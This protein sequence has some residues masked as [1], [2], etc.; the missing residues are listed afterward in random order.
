[1]KILNY[2]KSSNLEPSLKASWLI[3]LI[4]SIVSYVFI[5][6]SDG[7]MRTPLL[8]SS[9]LNEFLNLYQ[10]PIKTLTATVVLFGLWL[11]IERMKQTEEQTNAITDNNRFNNFYKHRD[12]FINFYKTSLY[13]R[14]TLLYTKKV[15]IIDESDAY[16]YPIYS[17]YYYSSYHNFQP[18][19]NSNIIKNEI[20]LLDKMKTSLL[21]IL[22]RDLLDNDITDIKE[23]FELSNFILSVVTGDGFMMSE[24]KEY[25]KNYIKDNNT[26]PSGN[27]INKVVLLIPLY[28]RYIFLLELMAFDGTDV[29]RFE[30]QHF[31]SN[32]SR[33]CIE[34]NLINKNGFRTKRINVD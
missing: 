28:W 25:K 8:N 30:C 31:E 2:F 11:T 12:D 32:Y 23:V 7:I 5:L 6:I 13:Y 14:L 29:S 3:G 20:A 21:N 33:F 16:F 22:N 26:K 27:E 1:M 24:F 19:R 34:Y 9:G 15:T 4:I 18:T 10:F 17:I